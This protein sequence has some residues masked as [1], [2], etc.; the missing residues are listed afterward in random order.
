MRTLEVW[1]TYEGPRAPERIETGVYEADDPR[2]FGLAVY[3]V[4]NGNARWLNASAVGVAEVVSED[5]GANA[6]AVVDTVPEDGPTNPDAG[7]LDQ[8]APEGDEAAAG[9]VEDEP[10]VDEPD[11]PTRRRGRRG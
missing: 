9:A 2:L 8:S 6:A 11:T 7:R 5:T 1:L 4:D 10:A 3:L